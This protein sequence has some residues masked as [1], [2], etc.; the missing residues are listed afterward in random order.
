MAPM[1]KLLSAEHIVSIFTAVLL[2]W[3]I[4]FVSKFLGFLGTAV[5]TAAD[6]VSIYKWKGQLESITFIPRLKEIVHPYIAGIESL[7]NDL[8]VNALVVYLDEDRL[9]FPKD[10]HNKDLSL[11]QFP[12]RLPF[13]EA[14]KKHQKTLESKGNEP[15]HCWP[16]RTTQEEAQTAIRINQ[17][18][19]EQQHSIRSTIFTPTFKKAFTSVE[20]HKEALLKHVPKAQREFF[21]QFMSSKS[22][23]LFWAAQHKVLFA[24]TSSTKV[25]RS[26]TKSA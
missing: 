5:M 4:L 11:P 2:E 22:F 12:D 16:Y 25:V 15:S 23:T 8:P 10:F 3:N 13:I 1:L 9:L 19:I 18:F 6:F 20:Q 26:R 17:L 14:L 24:K 7:P 21:D